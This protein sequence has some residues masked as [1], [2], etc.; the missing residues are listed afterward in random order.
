MNIKDAVF[1][2]AINDIFD[3]HHMSDKYDKPVIFFEESHFTDGFEVPDVEIVDQIAQIAGK[4]NIMIKLHPRSIVNRFARVGYKTNIDA[5]IPWEVIVLNR[6]FTNKILIAIASGSVLYPYLY[7]GIPLKSFSLL[8]TL[9]RRPGMLNSSLGDM[10]NKM[11]QTYP[12]VFYAPANMNN[13]LE[14]LA[15]I[16]KTI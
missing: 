8:N 2:Q 4:D 12:S 6:D 15:Q 9:P 10:M 16:M 1:V 3:L 13:F 5:N 7:F 14:T 11:Y